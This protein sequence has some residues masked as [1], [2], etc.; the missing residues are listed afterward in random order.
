[1]G[2]QVMIGTVETAMGKFDGNDWV[3]F[4]WTSGVV[5]YDS[6]GDS[7]EDGLLHPAACD[8]TLSEEKNQFG[9]FECTI[10]YQIDTPFGT[11]VNP[12]YDQI[13]L[14]KSWVSV[15]EDG[16][17][18]WVGYVS[19]ME[20]RFNLDWWIHADGPLAL[21]QDSQ[22]KIDPGTYTLTNE[23]GPVWSETYYAGSLFTLPFALTACP[24]GAFYI[25]T[26]NM[27]TGETL[28]TTDKGT[29]LDTAWNV[30][31][32]LFLEEYDGYLQ[33]R[34][35]TSGGVW[36]IRVDYLKDITETTKQTIYYG[37][38]LL[39]LTYSLKM[40][41][42]F[43]TRV[44]AYGTAT[45]SH[46]WWI[47]KKVSVTA[48][49]AVASNAEAEAK[50]GV[51]GKLLAVD[52]DV[53]QKSLQEA[54]DKE[55]KNYKQV[56]E[57]TLDIEAFDQVDEGADTDRLGFLKKTHVIS[58]PH[59][60]DGWYVCTKTSLTLDAPD[61]KRFTYGLPPRKLTDQQSTS[62]ASQKTTDQKVSGILS[63][64]N[65]LFNKG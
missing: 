15:L 42:N 56:I 60:V 49:A 17:P 64:L 45:E 47:W 22:T 58:A 40:E 59:G 26:V 6:A 39:D 48:I 20:K 27:K 23:P 4:R 34:I 35:E 2:Y 55:L 11:Y 21:M 65:K 28:D 38:N 13:Q 19:E 51:V 33:T 52:G 44:T 31:E 3:G 24:L 63:W 8:L 18:I 16:K 53:T 7:I 41:N 57:P 43:A 37:V 29:I 32:S 14:K 30:L 36:R 50:Y 62:A 46:G 5:I 54:A 1:M 10:P 9:A 12:I 25:G 61:S